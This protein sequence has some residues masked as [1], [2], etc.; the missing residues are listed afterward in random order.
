MAIYY[1][2]LEERQYRLTEPTLL[3]QVFPTGGDWKA[4]K[5]HADRL[6]ERY[7]YAIH[8]EDA[9]E[10]EPLFT[11]NETGMLLLDFASYFNPLTRLVE[12]VGNKV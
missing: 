8:S 2:S 10:D 9:D 1:S 7:N 12:A 3:K 11:Y 4:F 6:L 5:E